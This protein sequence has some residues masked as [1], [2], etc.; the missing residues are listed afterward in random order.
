MQ[1]VDTVSSDTALSKEQNQTLQFMGSP[2]H[3]P[4]KHPDAHA[5]RLKITLVRLDFLPQHPPRLS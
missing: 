5:C 1:L 3:A 4:D 2:E